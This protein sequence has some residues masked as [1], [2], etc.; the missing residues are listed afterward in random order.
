M[1]GSSAR[2]L[3]VKQL[4]TEEELQSELKT[5]AVEIANNLSKI[6][7][8]RG[9][10]LLSDFVSDLFLAV[11]ERKRKEENRR[12]QAAGIAAARARGVRFGRSERPLPDNFNDIHRAWRSGQLTLNQA[13]E[14]CGMP[15]A[16][17]YDK[18]VRKERAADQ[19]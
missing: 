11:A 6:D 7:G 3:P 13:A 4:S 15:V 9:K 10:E 14:S 16:T 8:V 17:F 5:L 12:R 2:Q 19:E 1:N 18:A